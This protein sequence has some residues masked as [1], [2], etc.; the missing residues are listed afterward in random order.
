[1][2]FGKSARW[3]WDHRAIFEAGAFVDRMKNKD[4]DWTV[5]A[6]QRTR[7]SLV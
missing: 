7:L 3:A 5:K 1:M 6:V 4:G 2:I